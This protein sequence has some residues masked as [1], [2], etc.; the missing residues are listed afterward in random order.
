MNVP[1]S[2]RACTFET[3][4]A[5]RCSCISFSCFFLMAGH[6]ITPLLPLREGCFVTSTSVPSSIL[7][8]VRSFSAVSLSSVAMRY[9]S[10]FFCSHLSIFSSKASIVAPMAHGSISPPSF[11]RT[12]KY[13]RIL[14]FS[15]CHLSLITF[16]GERIE[17]SVSTLGDFLVC[18]STL[19]RCFHP[20][21]SH[22]GVWL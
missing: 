5:D 16:C 2:P 6:F 17:I 14:G 4:C 3:F 9:S 19:G 11:A 18:P 21:Q 22:S 20:S 10:F 13:W 8:N 7:T 1:F 15:L 12:V